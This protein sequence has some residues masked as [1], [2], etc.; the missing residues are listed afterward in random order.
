MVAKTLVTA[1]KHSTLFVRERFQWLSG[2]GRRVRA[3]VILGR[4]LHHPIILNINRQPT[5]APISNVRSF[6]IQPA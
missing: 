4:R 2:N 5:K 1:A 3:S 6:H